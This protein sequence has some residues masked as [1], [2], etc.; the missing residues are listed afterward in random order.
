MRFEIQGDLSA[1]KVVPAVQSKMFFQKITSGF[2]LG[3]IMDPAGQRQS[4][5]QSSEFDPS[6]AV[7]NYPVRRDIYGFFKREITQ[8]DEPG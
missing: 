8:F 3:Q 6:V 4:S 1:D 5:L 2:Q 7:E